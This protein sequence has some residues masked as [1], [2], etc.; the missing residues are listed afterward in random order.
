MAAR[1]VE[2]DDIV[3]WLLLL[4]PSWAY[5][6]PRPKRWDRPGGRSI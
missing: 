1:A 6:R 2:I 4:V 3:T 5:Q